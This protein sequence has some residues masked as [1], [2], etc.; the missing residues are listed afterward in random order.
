MAGNYDVRR[1]QN[2]LFVLMVLQSSLTFPATFIG[3]LFRFVYYTYPIDVSGNV[4][5]KA[6]EDFAQQAVAKGL[7]VVFDVRL[8]VFTIVQ[9]P[10]AYH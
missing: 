3:F 7:P 1:R 8:N 4:T 5:E 2:E 10:Y 6:L 9:V